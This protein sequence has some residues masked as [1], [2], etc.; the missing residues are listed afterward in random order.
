MVALPRRSAVGAWAAVAVNT[1]EW[2]QLGRLEPLDRGELIDR[3]D[4]RASSQTPGVFEV[5]AAGM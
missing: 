4:G 5:R 2:L 3:S 1:S